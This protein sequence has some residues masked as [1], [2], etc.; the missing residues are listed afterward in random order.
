[1]FAAIL[2][3]GVLAACGGHS[4][5]SF[6]LPSFHGA[7]RVHQLTQDPYAV[8]VLNDSPTVYYRL[9]DT[10]AIAADSSG[11]GHNAAVGSAVTESAP[12][13]LTSS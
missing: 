7:R 4:Q 11:S 9:D 10:G 6:L 13:L 1:M 5:Q 8:A 3:V 12:G 2:A